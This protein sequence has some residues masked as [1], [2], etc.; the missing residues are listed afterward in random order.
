MYCI[1]K[2]LQ[3]KGNTFLL[4]YWFCLFIPR[5]EEMA[6][7]VQKEKERKTNCVSIIH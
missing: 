6:C 5:D 4:I 2:I 7:T 1:L 3:A